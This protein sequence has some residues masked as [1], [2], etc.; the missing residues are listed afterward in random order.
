MTG[1]FL[2][3]THG[4]PQSLPT[5]TTKPYQSASKVVLFFDATRGLLEIVCNLL[6]VV[7]MFRVGLRVVCGAVRAL[8]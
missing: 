5:I 1:V 2:P 8:L 7:I 4:F 3:T 6:K